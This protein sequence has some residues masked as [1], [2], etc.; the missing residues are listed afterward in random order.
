[1]VADNF[2][3][4]WLIRH[5]ESVWNL[6]NRFQGQADPL[7]S[8]TGQRQATALGKRLAKSEVTFR[9]IYSS[10]LRRSIQTANLV[11]PD[12]DLI[13]DKRLRERSLGAFEG[14]TIDE[15]DSDEL[16]NY[17]AWKNDPENTRPLGGE[18]FEE[19][20]RRARSWLSSLP[21][22][23]GNIIAFT[24][25]GLVKA[26]IYECLQLENRSY[27]EFLIS[28]ISICKLQF[29]K[30]KVIVVTI[31]DTAHWEG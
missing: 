10:D 28:N 5:G 24:H 3:N 9:S 16:A 21:N 4:V 22:D 30:N 11:F 25:G 18:I 23:G 1:M 17:E 27:Q 15:F 19:L 7:L 2:V 20:K 8:E 6:E 14:K 12:K 31:N 26:I 29:V 13:I